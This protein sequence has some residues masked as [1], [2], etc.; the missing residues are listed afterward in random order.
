MIGLLASVAQYERELIRE[1]S[2][3][4]LRTAR[5]KGKHGGRP[6]ALNAEKLA[7]L[8]AMDR[9]GLKPE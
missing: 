3:A 5:A 9:A 1:R 2:T 8:D 6:R 7:R 4:G